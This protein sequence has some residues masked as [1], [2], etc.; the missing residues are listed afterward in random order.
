MKFDETQ[1]SQK[2]RQQAFLLGLGGLTLLSLAASAYLTQQARK[3]FAAAISD[4]LTEQRIVQLEN[5]LDK[6]KETRQH[7]LT[8]APLS[9]KERL[10]KFLLKREMQKELRELREEYL[11]QRE[12]EA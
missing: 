9:W 4:A 10:G 6:L 2:R 8:G 11:A 5:A 1:L 12:A 3:H 7:P